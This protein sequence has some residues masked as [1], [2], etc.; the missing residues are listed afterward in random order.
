MK[1]VLLAL[2]IAF[3]GCGA[4][5][6][7]DIAKDLVNEK[8]KTTLPDFS[9][10]E[11]LNFGAL[12]KAFLPFE[13]TSQYISN[14]KALTAYKDSMAVLE[15]MIKE[16]KTTPPAGATYQERLQQLQDSINALNERNHTARQ[17]YTPEQLFKITHAYI[18]KDD[19][20]PDKKTEQEFYFD[21]D[22]KK[23]LKFHK[24]Y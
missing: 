21:K 18:I 6:N 22:L 8:L 9:K 19:A 15:K 20:G 12:G 4:K 3:A 14:K 5:S 16:K 11:S 24:V 10:Y 1:I 7:E 13:E 23:V 2:C 17:T